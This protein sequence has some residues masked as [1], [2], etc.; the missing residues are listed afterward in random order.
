MK[1]TP[2]Y[3]DKPC[4]ACG[5]VFSPRTSH[6][7]YCSVPCR[8]WADVDKSAGPDACWPW[9]A[10]ITPTTGYGNFCVATKKND[11]A[12]RVA[13]RLACGDIPKGMFVCHRCDNRPCVNPRHLFLGTP[14]DNTRD[15]F[16]K[17]RQKT[18]YSNAQRGE[19]RHNAALTDA[20]VREIRAAAHS[21]TRAALAR[22]YG[23]NITTI[24]SVV[25]GRTW[26]HVLPEAKEPEHG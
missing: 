11:A 7:K 23:V 17:G 26:K 2:I 5:V 19:A 16:S 9:A 25:D 10:T 18:D 12:H 15:M 13:Y 6:M 14:G 21:T 4:V 3:K 20:K 1:K 24:C 8:F 22:R